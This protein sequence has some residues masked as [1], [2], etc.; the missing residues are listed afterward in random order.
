MSERNGEL[1]PE[2]R[3]KKARKLLLLWFGVIA[4]YKVRLRK[5]YYAFPRIAGAHIRPVSR[6]QEQS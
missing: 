1:D 5:I 3:G 4:Q 6:T 2:L